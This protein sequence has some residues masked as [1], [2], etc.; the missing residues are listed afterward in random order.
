MTPKSHAKQSFILGIVISAA[1]YALLFSPW[2]RHSILHDYT[3]HHITEVAIVVLFFWANSELLFCFLRA[4]GEQKHLQQ[5]WLPVSDGSDDPATA[6]LLLQ[7]L[8]S[9]FGDLRTTY[10]YRRLHAALTFVSRRRST[11][12]FREYLD[13]LA[14]RDRDDIHSHY[15]FS[16]FV[17]AILPILGLIG[18]VIHFGTALTGLSMDGLETKIPELLS[19]MGTAFNTTCTAMSCMAVTLLL[20][21]VIEG[22]ENGV[23]NKID[24]FMENNL[25]FRFASSESHREHEG[26]D[27]S[28][29]APSVQALETKFS[30]LLNVWQQREAMF[31]QHQRE[32]IGVLKGLARPEAS[33]ERPKARLSGRAGAETLPMRVVADEIRVV[34]EDS[35]IEPESQLERLSA[36]T[37][38]FGRDARQDDGERGRRAA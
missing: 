24:H 27:A 35:S 31:E 25:L 13:V 10:F 16:R 34:A 29:P 11:S 4:R 18:T 19:G 21:F 22:M 12:E 1:Y 32:L 36:E 8:E 7:R 23:A 37:E 14:G 26:A 15:G 38:E 20:R 17:T 5:P 3:A 28:S 30:E 2:M 9:M 6:R 33:S